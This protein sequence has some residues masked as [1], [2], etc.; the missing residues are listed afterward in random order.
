M[1]LTE[2]FKKYI[3]NQYAKPTGFLGMYFGEKMV[4]QHQSETLWTIK[5]LKLHKDE[6]ILELGC[7][8]GYAM[9][10]LLEQPA[11]SKVVGV[12]ISKFILKSAMIRNRK[13]IN[14][15]RAEL[16]Q[17][18]VNQLDFKDAYFT[19][20]FSIHSIYFWDNLPN[21]LSE[22]YRVLKPEGL[23]ILTL[24]D[25][26]NGETFTAIKDMLEQQVIPIMKQNGFKNIE[27]IKGPDSRQF[28]NIAVKGHK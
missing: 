14:E 24:C 1:K 8:A 21:T 2:K 10:R 25:G 22:I 23:I 12:D 20:V 15:G 28:Q 27:L 7:G 16:I 3:D 18:N 19:K 26:K 13:K 9:S 11:V 5:L 4:Q 6:T 17:S